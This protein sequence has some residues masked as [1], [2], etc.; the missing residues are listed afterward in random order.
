MTFD[1]SAVY[2]GNLEWL[3]ARTLYVTR[4]GSHAYG[5][6]TPDSDLDLRGIC[7]APMQYYLGFS[8]AFEQVVQN[9]PI[10][11]TVF[12]LR[13]FMKLASDANPNTL[14]ILYTD[15]SDHLLVVPLMERLLDNRDLFL[16]KKVK[17]TFSGYSR[18]QMKRINTHYRWLKNPPL[19]PPTRAEFD[20]PERTVIPADQLD[21]AESAVKK[22][23]D[24]WSW[25]E[26]E[27]LD[28]ATRQAMQDE[29]SR[30]LL[31]I[32]QWSW[33]EVGEKL[34]NTAAKS[35]GYDANFIEYLDM[36]RRYTAR[37][38]E[39]QHYQDWKAKRNPKRAALEAKFGY[40][41]K[42]A[43]HL[44]RLARMC[45]EILTTGQV[46][47]R[48]PDAEELLEIRNGAWT[49]EQL[50]EFSDRQDNEL[51]T[52]VKISTLPKQPDREKLDALCEEMILSF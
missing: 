31:E 42:H 1:M 39:W 7:V 11:L 15:P 18:A 26:L 23:V 33:D 29:F 45:R 17:H 51:E 32:T 44:I 38:R 52:L 50:V 6:S 37:L 22:Q 49:Y 27:H 13:K 48:R 14:E 12:E 40:D 5:T 3:P 10:D 21:A 46:L 20:L 2:T 8:K 35:V 43:C 47:V 28:P 41:C 9:Q 34:Y 25:R 16:S 4:H 30:R 36:E 24:R 19:A